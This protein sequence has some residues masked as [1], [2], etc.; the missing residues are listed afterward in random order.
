MSGA[1]LAAGEDLPFATHGGLAVHHVFP[2]DGEYVFTIR[3]KRNGTVSTID[4]IEEDEHQ[5]EI[6]VDHALIKRFAIG[7]KFKGPDPGMLIAPPEDDVEGRKLHDYRVNAD[8]DLEIRVPIKAGER[9]VSVAF[10]DSAPSPLESVRSARSGACRA[11]HALHRRPV[12]RDDA[13]GD[14]PAA[15]DFRLSAAGERGRRAVRPED[16]HHAREARLP[17][18]GDRARR[19]A[20]AGDLQGRARRARISTPA[21]SGRSK[22]CCRRRNS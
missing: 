16:H 18:A 21:S 17:P 3:L 7:G 8:K 1:T 12:Q 20:A 15:G 19:R 11:R 22:R 13:S 10:T 6:R 4:G 2:L 5:I 9:L 14:T